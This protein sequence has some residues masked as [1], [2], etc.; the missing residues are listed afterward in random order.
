MPSGNL[1]IRT[2]A[3]ESQ[4]DA[5]ANDMRKCPHCGEVW[6]K[7]VGCS[8]ETTCGN[9]V[10]RIDSTGVMATFTF[11]WRDGRLGITKTGER[12]L[13][14]LQAQIN[15][16]FA[17]SSKGSRSAGCG[18]TISWDLMRRV[19]IPDGFYDGQIGTDDIDVLPEQAAPVRQKIREGLND[20]MAQMRGRG[21]RN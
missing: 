8:G 4:P 9:M 7:I 14:E 6:A 11:N 2:K 19:D 1:D 15:A 3:Q 13:E 10:N 21:R 16:A 12:R 20:R 18:R 5:G 17:K